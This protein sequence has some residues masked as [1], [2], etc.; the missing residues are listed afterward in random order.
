MDDLP[1][2]CKICASTVFMAMKGNNWE[3]PVLADLKLEASE[4]CKLSCW[5]Q[6]EEKLVY[7]GD[8]NKTMKT[9]SHVLECLEKGEI[10]RRNNLPST[11]MLWVGLV[12]PP[13]RGRKQIFTHD[14]PDW[15]PAAEV[16]FGVTCFFDLLQ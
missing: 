15:A 13:H 10:K 5:K 11:P 12:G 2:L 1:F 9:S 8:F 7:V 16:C 4:N 3:V 6:L 14:H